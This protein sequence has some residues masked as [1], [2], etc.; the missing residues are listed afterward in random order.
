MSGTTNEKNNALWIIA[1][2]RY[3]TVSDLNIT[4]DFAISNSVYILA[5]IVLVYKVVMVVF[6]F[7]I[8]KEKLVHTK[9][10]TE[11]YKEIEKKVCYHYYRS[12]RRSYAGS[13]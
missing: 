5:L 2:N 3:S 13:Y 11:K 1:Q 6:F 4:G 12:T 8:K 9:G 7:L 10:S